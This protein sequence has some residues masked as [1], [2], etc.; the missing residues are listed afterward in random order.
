M[1]PFFDIEFGKLFSEN[2]VRKTIASFAKLKSEG[3][4][5]FVISVFALPQ[6][7]KLASYLQNRS[8]VR[9]VEPIRPGR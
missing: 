3:M 4:L 5:Y 9:K 2:M 6:V 1:R 8:L 7:C